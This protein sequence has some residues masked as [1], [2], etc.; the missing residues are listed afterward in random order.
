MVDRVALEMRSTGNRTGGS[1]PS[2]SANN[3]QLASGRNPLRWLGF[4]LHLPGK[5][6]LIKGVW[7]ITVPL[8]GGSTCVHASPL[9]SLK[10]L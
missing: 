3:Q 5:Y 10:L 1:N 7:R 9:V 4:L 6:K 2:L 8:N